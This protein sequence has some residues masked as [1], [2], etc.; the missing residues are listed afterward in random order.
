MKVFDVTPPPAPTQP[1]S[2]TMTA[3]SIGDQVT[4]DWEASPSN[5]ADDNVTSYKLVI[6]EVGTDITVAEPVIDGAT[7]HT[8][9]GTFGQHLYAFVLPI[10]AAGI[11]GSPSTASGSV[12]LLDPAADED[13]D[14]ENNDAEDRAGTDPM[15]QASVFRVRSITHEGGAN[16]RITWDSVPG[17]Q[18]QLEANNTVSG[19]YTPVSGVITAT[20]SSTNEVVTGSGS[21]QFFQVRLI[22]P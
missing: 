18:Y 12:K 3:Y 20:G 4:F 14:G 7:Q 1:G 11:E 10:S 21:Y 8:F 15:D 9:S 16:Y 17:K 19:A 22:E 2:I 13:A 6:K 5:T